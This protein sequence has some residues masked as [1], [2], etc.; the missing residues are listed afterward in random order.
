[1]EEIIGRV[2]LHLEDY[3]GEDLYSDGDIEDEMLTI[4]KDYEPSE[5]DR[6]VEERH[7]W[8]ILYHFSSIRTNIL[9]W[10]P[11]K[12]TDKV[13]E[14]GSGCGAISG[15]IAKKV[16]HLTCIELS[17]KRSMI[18][19]Y[20]N[21]TQDNMDIYLGNF[22][23]VEKKMPNDF[24]VITLIGVFEYG[25]EYIASE[26]PY[27]DFLK[28]VLKHLKPGGHLMIA[29]ENRLGMKYFA[30]ATE[31]HEG[32]YFEGIEGYPNT[33]RVHTFS[34]PE[35]E[36]IMDACGAVNRTFYYPYPDYKLPMT[37]YSDQYLPKK[38]E[39]INNLVNFDRRRILLFDEAKAY[40]SILDSGLFPVFSNSYCI[41]ITG[42]EI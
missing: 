8:P 41:D 21:R 19:A 25:S 3:P 13:L 42:G 9:N 10:Y 32:T 34:K 35:L 22:Q 5:F 39:L 2:T 24:D 37:I 14:I 11:F 4:A 17:K 18:N 26:H 20:R 15:S 6:I 29:I 28:I 16:E 36:A 38:G 12:K 33:K 23:D 31:D 30:G 27:V 1:M 7:S 40:D